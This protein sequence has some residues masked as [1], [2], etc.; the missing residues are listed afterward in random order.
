MKASLQL[1][2]ILFQ[3]SQLFYNISLSLFLLWFCLDGQS[4]VNRSGPCV[5]MVSL[6]SDVFLTEFDGASVLM[7]LCPF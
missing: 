7:S 5:Y 6:F 4:A 3:R 1:Q 2:P